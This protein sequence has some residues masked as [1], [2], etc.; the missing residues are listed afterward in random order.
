MAALSI[1]GIIITVVGLIVFSYKGYP[2]FFL[3]P[4][5]AL[6]VLIFSGQNI[7]DGF[8]TTYSGSFSGFMQKYFLVIFLGSIFGSIMGAS[9]AAKS[10]AVKFARLAR[11]TKGNTKL[12]A[13]YAI[14]AISTVL[15]YGG[16]S[17][18]VI[19]F[20][21]LA[22]AKELFQEMD[23]PWRFF[24]FQVIGSGVLSMTMLPGS[25][26]VPNVV[27]TT[28][29]GTSPM[30]GP[31][32]AFIAVALELIF[33]SI[34]IQYELKKSQGEGFFPSGTEIEKVSISSG[35]DGF[36]ELNLLVALAP[37]ILLIVVLNVLKQHIIVATFAG[38]ILSIILYW[39]VWKEKV[40]TALSG[41]ETAVRASVLISMFVAGAAVITSTEGFKVILSYIEKIPGP[42]VIQLIIIVNM[43]AMLASS[44]SG[45]LSIGLGLAAERLLAGGMNPNVLH[46]ISTISC[47]GLGFLP[48]NASVINE[49]NVIRVTHKDGYKPYLVCALIFPIIISLIL[50]VVSQFG[51]V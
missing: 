42:P 24:G 45:G 18:F 1:V 16:I 5:G 38:I 35:D 7:V 33:C 32:L 2:P 14:I 15:A 19:M 37:S 28:T 41:A 23:V 34:Y 48:S 12:Y 25:P 44:G 21:L 27:A 22:I 31:T 20:T 29:L 39:N 36:K 50:A 30:A 40:K 8:V 9:G 4:I 13:I 49:L 6:I 47:A 3:A 10:I 11:K 17:N 46:R 26:S 51:I 43:S